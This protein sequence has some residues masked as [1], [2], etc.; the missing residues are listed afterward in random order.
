MYLIMYI[1]GN[2]VLVIDFVGIVDSGT[3]RNG[4]YVLEGIIENQFL[5]L[6]LCRFLVCV[7][8]ITDEASQC[9][10]SVYDYCVI[11]VTEKVCHYCFEKVLLFHWL[12]GWLWLDD[13]ETPFYR[14]RPFQKDSVN[15]VL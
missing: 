6:S 8:G 12:V 15:S 10:F 9:S 4:L 5:F 14:T 7:D 11:L 3:E 1:F 13:I 2:L